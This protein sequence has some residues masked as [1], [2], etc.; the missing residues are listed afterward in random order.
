MCGVAVRGLIQ[1]IPREPL[2][3]S[4]V[5]DSKPIFPILGV[6]WLIGQPKRDG[7]IIVRSCGA[8]Q[9]PV[10]PLNASSRTGLVS[11]KTPRIRFEVGEEET[12]PVAKHSDIE[13]SLPQTFPHPAPAT[14]RTPNVYLP[15]TPNLRGIGN[16]DVGNR[17]AVR[18]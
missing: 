14:R 13:A 4:Y 7:S 16:R 1:I 2:N 15:F 12:N 10:Y 8:C 6:F 17:P 18:K 9:L 3:N 11:T 5:M